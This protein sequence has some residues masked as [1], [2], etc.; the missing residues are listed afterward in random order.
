MRFLIFG[1]IALL[2]I[3]CDK[4]VYDM[5]D[6]HK[7]YGSDSNYVGAYLTEISNQKVYFGHQS[8]GRNI[9][10]G[11]EKWEDNEGVKLNHF[12]TSSLRSSM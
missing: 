1:V 10:S 7:V 9:I 2:F 3:S 11:I 6:F 12:S 4:N 8:V 5:N